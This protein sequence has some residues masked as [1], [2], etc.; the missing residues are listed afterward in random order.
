M[1]PIPIGHG[2][3][4][5]NNALTP[6][7]FSWL[8]IA[9]TARGTPINKIPKLTSTI[10]KT[11][12][13]GEKNAFSGGPASNPIISVKTLPIAGTIRAF[14]AIDSSFSASKTPK[15][16][17]IYPITRTPITNETTVCI[18]TL[19]PL[20]TGFKNAPTPTFVLS[21]FQYSPLKESTPHFA[22]FQTSAPHIVFPSLV[23]SHSLPSSS[24]FPAPLSSHPSSPQPHT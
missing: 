2:N 4:Q 1:P 13:R 16:F 15:H 7:R 23:P 14:C 9:P 22:F 21:F 6:K 17:N 3:K 5:S 8:R 19:L 11:L 10:S 24:S 20:F 12:P 18:V